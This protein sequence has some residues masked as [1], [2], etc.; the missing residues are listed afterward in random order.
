MGEAEDLQDGLSQL[1]TFPGTLE[2]A[3]SDVRS[4]A[5]QIGNGVVELVG[6]HTRHKGAWREFQSWNERL[7]TLLGELQ[8]HAE[9]LQSDRLRAAMESELES[10][11][12]GR[13]K[14]LAE[15]EA[16]EAEEGDGQESAAKVEVVEEDI[17]IR[18][19]ESADG[20]VTVEEEIRVVVAEVEEE[21]E[22]RGREPTSPAP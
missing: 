19:V 11:R 12:A 20:S 15:W 14:R 1:D 7:N 10:V 3:V 17:S 8:D 21:G 16:E 6:G 2:K 18:I 13:Q 9:S 22:E 4:S 5:D